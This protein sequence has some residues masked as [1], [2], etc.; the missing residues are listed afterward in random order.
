MS[1]FMS[2]AA[3]FSALALAGA[4]SLVLAAQPIGELD[5][6]GQVRVSQAD[7][8]GA[9]ALSDTTYGWFSGDRID[10][11]SGHAL[12][13]L[14]NNASFGFG[15]NT[16]ASI[17]Q[18]DGELRVSLESGVVLY[19]VDNGQ[20]KLV[21]DSGDYSFQSQSGEA[22][23]IQVSADSDWSIGLVEHDAEGQVRV[24]VREGFMHATHA[25]GG[26]RYQVASGDNVAFE[27][28]EARMVQVQ[29]MAA[30]QN[31]GDDDGSLAFWL[32][33]NAVPAGLTLIM[34]GTLIERMFIQDRDAPAGTT[35][36][37]P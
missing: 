7:V 3:L 19:A 31:P 15:E 13:N 22:R 6:R 36:V 2:T 5:I 8:D 29:A 10:T 23:A 11:R 37:S 25:E 30:R 33:N 12:L 18:V 34:T 17:A 16:R 1:R 35:P 4:S 9:V 21:V 20:F 28:T 32:Q 24:S 27:G 26:L 14:D